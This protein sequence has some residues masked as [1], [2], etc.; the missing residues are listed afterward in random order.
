MPSMIRL[1]HKPKLQRHQ[2]RETTKGF[3]YIVNMVSCKLLCA[4]NTTDNVAISPRHA[5][6]G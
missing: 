1:K 4:P 6:G 5:E 2:K 3:E